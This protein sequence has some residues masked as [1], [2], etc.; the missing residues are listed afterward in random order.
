[1][2]Q[3]HWSKRLWN[4][5]HNELITERDSPLLDFSPTN[6]GSSSVRDR[7]ARTFSQ[8]RSGARSPINS[9]WCR[10]NFCHNDRALGAPPR[11]R[12]C[13]STTPRAQPRLGKTSLATSTTV[14]SE[15]GTEA[16]PGELAI[17]QEQRSEAPDVAWSLCTPPTHKVSK[18]GLT[19]SFWCRRDQFH[20]IWTTVARTRPTP[21]SRDGGAAMRYSAPRP[22]AGESPSTVHRTTNGCD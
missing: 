6:V 20:W 10:S 22:K 13:R 15:D 1:M 3:R 17:D 21:V 16:S 12:L 8:L 5:V 2:A 11:R 19:S 7:I 4:R 18:K 14:G 9:G